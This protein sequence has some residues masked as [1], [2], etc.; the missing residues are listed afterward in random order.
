MKAT[1]TEIQII[2]ALSQ[3]SYLP[4]TFD[5]SFPRQIDPQDIS[6]LQQYW[7][8]KLGYKYRKQINN[9]NLLT[10]CKDFLDT[11]TQPISR[12][13]ANKLLKQTT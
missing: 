9:F 8:Y 2:K 7:I 13:Q 11:H 4:G 3:C 5:K 10:I 6:P 12:K 1:N